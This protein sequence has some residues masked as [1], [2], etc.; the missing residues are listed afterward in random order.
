[1]AVEPS[2]A[3]Q[4]RAQMALHVNIFRGLHRLLLVGWAVWVLALIGPVTWDYWDL[5]RN[6]ASGSEPKPAPTFKEF[7]IHREIAECIKVA[8]AARQPGSGASSDPLKDF[9]TI[10]EFL[11][12]AHHVERNLPQEYGQIVTFLSKLVLVPAVL[13]G[14]L[15]A[16]AYALRWVWRGLVPSGGPKGK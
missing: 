15:F 14:G 13:Y 5:S 11:N 16:L 9:A 10:D 7:L 1:V 6:R 4:T 8:I 2:S 12:C 3:R